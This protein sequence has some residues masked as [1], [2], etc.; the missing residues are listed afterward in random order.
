VTRYAAETTVPAERSRG[1]IERTLA[2]YGAA[3]FMYGWEFDRAVIVF[4][5]GEKYGY[6]QIRFVI[7]MPDR[8]AFRKTPTGRRR[9]DSQMEKEYEQATRQRWRALLL[10]VKAKLEAVDSGIASFDQEFLAHIM[11]PTG[12]TVGEWIAPGLDDAYI[13]GEMPSPLRLALPAGVSEP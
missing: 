9:T 11:L 10:V 7:E 1:E 13:S 6:R 5:M 8:A 2:R 3:Q 4:K 12:E